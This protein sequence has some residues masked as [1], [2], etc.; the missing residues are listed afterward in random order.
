MYS[1]DQLERLGGPPLT[2]VPPNAPLVTSLLPI[3]TSIDPTAPS[4]SVFFPEQTIPLPLTYPKND[5]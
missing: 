3:L 2:L 4:L 1:L 5:A